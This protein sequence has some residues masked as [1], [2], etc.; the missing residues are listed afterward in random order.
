LTAILMVALGVIAR[1]RFRPIFS[2][3]VT[4]AISRFRKTFDVP[5]LL[6]AA[7][8]VYLLAVVLLYRNQHLYI[9]KSFHL[10]A[11]FLAYW[12][13]GKISRKPNLKPVT[14]VTP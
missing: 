14:G 6:I 13:T 4:L 3:T 8:L 1:A 10:A 9:L 12:V 7:D 2:T 5:G 11:P